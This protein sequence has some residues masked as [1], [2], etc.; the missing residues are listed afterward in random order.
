MRSL[1]VALAA[2]EQQLL[3]LVEGRGTQ[4]GV[5]PSRAALY[6]L[7]MACYVA[8]QCGMQVRLQLVEVGAR[9]LLVGGLVILLGTGSAEQAAGRLVTMHLKAAQTLLEMVVWEPQKG[10]CELYDAAQQA[11]QPDLTVKWLLQL[12]A[13]LAEA[14]ADS[15]GAGFWARPAGASRHVVLFVTAPGCRLAPCLITASCAAKIAAPADVLLL[16]PLSSPLCSVAPLCVCVQAPV[17]RMA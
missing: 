8:K 13:Y 12:T 9:L 14:E 3:R 2:L 7:H 16:A 15:E 1:A 6:T 11:F 10:P 17:Q 4:A 5:A